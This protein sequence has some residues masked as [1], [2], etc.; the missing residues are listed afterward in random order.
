MKYFTKEWYDLMQRMNYTCGMKCIPD[1]EYTDAEIKALYDRKLKKE[2]A[3]N[4]KLHNTPV[5]MEYLYDLLEPEKFD[6]NHFLF[7]NEETGEYFHPETPEI[8][9]AHIDEDCRRAREQFE[10]RP[11]FDPQETID[12]FAEVYHNLLRVAYSNLPEWAVPLL[13]KRLLALEYM[14]ESVYRQLRKE[15][16]KN[17]RAFERIMKKAEADLG[18]Q[19][20][21]EKMREG[22]CF[23]D[24]RLLSIKKAGTDVA[25]CL[26]KDG[27]WPEGTPY[28]R[29]IF[30]NVT[31][32]E[33]EKGLVIRKRMG[34]HGE[35]ESNYVYLYDEL[36]RTDTGYE[37]HILLTGK[38]LRY[39]T[40]GC[41]DV[42]FEDNIGPEEL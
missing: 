40:I 18:Q 26:R 7:W 12:F 6:P 17:K 19:A 20:I 2:I 10:Q 30:M 29:V 38:E 39:L 23:H 31:L 27:M 14:P 28:I 9:K 22:F 16:Q 33:R 5:N 24:A 32:F 1:K 41:E 34:Q 42:V 25:L 35:W 3:H 15:E 36:Y 8:A 13:D 37:I 11:S 21:P 4:R